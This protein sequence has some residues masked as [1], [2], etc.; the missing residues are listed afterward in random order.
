MSATVII[1]MWEVRGHP[2]RVP[3]LVDW[4]CTVGVAAVEHDPRHIRSEVFSSS[5]RVVVISRWRSEPVPLP[6]P[7]AELV[8]RAPHSWDFTPVD[9]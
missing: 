3:E 6:E 4:V 8:V 1:R 2:E 7:P 9:R 5:E